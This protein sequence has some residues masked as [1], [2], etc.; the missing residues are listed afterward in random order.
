MHNARAFEGTVSDGLWFQHVIAAACANV[1]SAK[2]HFM[3]TGLS[4]RAMAKMHVSTIAVKIARA[5]FDEYKLSRSPFVLG[6]S[7]EAML[8]MMRILRLKG[9]KQVRI[10]VP[11]SL[12]KIEL[13]AIAG[14]RTIRV[15]MY[16]RSL[17]SV[18]AEPPADM[19]TEIGAFT[20]D[21]WIDSKSAKSMMDE[22]MAVDSQCVRFDVK[23][24]GSREC[25]YVSAKSCTC[26]PVDDTGV[27][28]VSTSK[29]ARDACDYLKSLSGKARYDRYFSA[30]VQCALVKQFVSGNLCCS[31]L[32]V[33]RTSM[34]VY[35]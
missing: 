4:W 15:E 18:A 32:K 17:D 35:F 27:D 28:R 34:F 21:V 30:M 26:L 6:V 9:D 31:V 8:K 11:S 13:S 5:S 33:C 1:T 20:Y 25:Y 14:G 16:C 29:P 22:M 23:R 2:I 24:S 19:E 12:D 10:R 7:L 3:D